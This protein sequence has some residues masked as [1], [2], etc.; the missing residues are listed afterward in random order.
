[1]VEGW[2]GDVGRVF[3][4]LDATALRTRS[5]DVGLGVDRWA[6]GKDLTVVVC[7]GI[8]PLAAELEV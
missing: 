1:L 3:L 7:R 2:G 8:L 6:A 5:A 4:E